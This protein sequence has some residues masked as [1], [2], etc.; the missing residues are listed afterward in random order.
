MSGTKPAA[1]KLKLWNGRIYN[2]EHGYIAAYS[3]ADAV[4]VASE[5]YPRARITPH[6]L[7][8]YWHCGTWGDQMIGITPERGIWIEEKGNREIK[9]VVGGKLLP[10]E[11]GPEWEEAQR[12]QQSSRE[13]YKAQQVAA[14]Q[15]RRERARKLFQELHGPVGMSFGIDKDVVEVEY[16]GHRFELREVED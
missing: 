6:E 1:K 8:I 11:R 3:V 5:E 16:M 13:Q 14:H 9:R 4:R 15:E 10:V 12:E 2:H 7:N